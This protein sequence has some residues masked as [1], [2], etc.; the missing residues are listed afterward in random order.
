MTHQLNKKHYSEKSDHAPLIMFSISTCNV[1]DQAE[2]GELNLVTCLEDKCGSILSWQ[3]LSFCHDASNQ[4]YSKDHVKP[5]YD[6]SIFPFLPGVPAINVPAK[7]S[8]QGLPI[9]LQL[10][11]QNFKDRQLL[12]IAK[13]FEQ[14]VQFPHHVLEEQLCALYGEESLR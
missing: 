3:I 1:L 4:I 7:L 9:G 8:S 12:T 5:N 2:Y 6:F 11:G 10:T 14:Q 13:W